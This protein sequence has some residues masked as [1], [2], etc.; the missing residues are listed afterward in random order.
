MKSKCG[1][2]DNVEMTFAMLAAPTFRRSE[3]IS[4]VTDSAMWTYYVRNII[5][6]S[7]AVGF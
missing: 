2:G 4:I 1:I 7:P 3:K 6:I 5:R